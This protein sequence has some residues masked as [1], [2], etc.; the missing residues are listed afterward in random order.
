MSL[1]A[2]RGGDGGSRRTNAAM[3]GLRGDALHV[4]LEL[5]S[6]ADVG[7]V[8]FPNAGK[9][10]LLRAVSSARPAVANYPFTTLRPHVSRQR[11]L[12]ACARI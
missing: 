1:R 3:G 7:L 6:I 10:S 12:E 4:R 2:C 11:A 8:G 5:K 9:S